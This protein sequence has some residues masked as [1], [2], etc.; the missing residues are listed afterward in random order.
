MASIIA[1]VDDRFVAL[2][3]QA[4]GTAY[5]L[6]LG[7]FRRS[8][9]RM[10]LSDPTYPGPRFDR[11]YELVYTTLGDLDDLVSNPSDATWRLDVGVELRVGYVYGRDAT[12]GWSPSASDS[13]ETAAYS[14]LNARARALNDAQLVWRCL[15]KNFPVTAD[16]V[17]IF[18]C[19]R[20]GAA[21]L[22]DLGGGRLVCTTPLRVRLEVAA[23]TQYL[24]VR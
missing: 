7:L 11:A 15:N 8:A 19:M 16:G 10:P 18:D 6:P 3:E 1:A 20:V 5:T 9:D 21:S 4:A 24:P 14:V 22:D 23:A 12:S 17:A 2:L 13:G